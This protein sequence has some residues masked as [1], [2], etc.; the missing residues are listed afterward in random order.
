MIGDYITLLT[1]LQFFL[2][3]HSHPKIYEPNWLTGSEGF[4]YGM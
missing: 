3:L 2:L 1:C 4:E